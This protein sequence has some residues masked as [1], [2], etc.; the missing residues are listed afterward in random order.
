MRASLASLL[1][2]VVLPTAWVVGAGSR[3][4]GF[5]TVDLHGH[6]W[7]IWNATRGP[8]THSDLVNAPYGLDLLPIVGGWL[9]IAVG[10]ALAPLVGVP[11]AYNLVL[12][13]YATLAGVGGAALARALGA[14]AGGALVAGLLLQLDPFVLLHLSS[15]RPEQAAVGLVALALAGAVATWERPGTGLAVATGV[16][17]AA[18]VFASWELAVLLALGMVAFGPVIWLSGGAAPGAPRRWALAA[19]V[20]AALAGPWAATFL[21][22][23]SA[24]RPLD[25]GELAVQLAVHASVPWLHWLRIDSTRPGVLALAA[26]VALPVVLSGSRRRLWGGALVCL[27]LAFVLAL[28]PMPSARPLPPHAP[29][30]AW[31]PFVWLQSL[32]GLGWFHWPDR[33]LLLLSVAASAAGG[34]L[35]SHVATRRRAL[36]AALGVVLVVMAAGRAAGTGKWPRGQFKMPT[37]RVFRELRDHPVAGGVVDLPLHDNGVPRYAPAL[38]QITHE[39]PIQ[40]AGAVPWALGVDARQSAPAGLWALSPTSQPAFS[41]SQADRERLVDEGFGVLALHRPRGRRRWYPA[42][43]AAISAELGPPLL[44][45]DNLGWACWS[46]AEPAP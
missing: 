39:R 18:V 42:A 6:L 21:R 2:F 22:R 14:G 9:D 12:A 32:P 7:T 44:R 20:T 30:Q 16:A 40:A 10:S 41:L 25:Q 28:G 5:D 19:G 34:V 33:L 8:M 1:A 31:G 35:V 27:L 46:L 24:V 3:V 37:H 13:L 15:G 11:L 43:V 38:A 45:D 29:V 26:L 17:G 4:V 23:A 36:G